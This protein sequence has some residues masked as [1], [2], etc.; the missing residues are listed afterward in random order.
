MH[1]KNETSHEIV[2]NKSRFIC[3]VNRI[4]DEQSAKD[5]ILS[6]RKLHPDASTIAYAYIAGENN[7]LQRSNDGGEPSGTAG[8]PM[9][10]CLK[11]SHVQNICAVTVRYFGGIKL[12]AGGLI[13]AFS[14]SVSETLKIA[15]KLK[16][17]TVYRY[18]IT[19]EYDLIGRIDYFLK[20]KAEIL[21][22]C[23]EEKVSYIFQ[24]EETDIPKEISELGK[25]KI[26]CEFLGAFFVD[27]EFSQEDLD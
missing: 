2:I 1:L 12:G 19:F 11:N 17:V 18:Q 22:K 7:E 16:T 27:K 10:E 15:P 13:R 3:Y 6:I 25:G 20:E 26:P 5:Y 9:L 24:T 4:D 14:K 23:Y 21:D 8:V